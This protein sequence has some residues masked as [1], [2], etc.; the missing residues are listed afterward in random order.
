M[1][2][3]LGA[4]PVAPAVKPHHDRAHKVTLS[5]TDALSWLAT[6]SR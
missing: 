4:A 5:V 3:S 2:G 6:S 1:G